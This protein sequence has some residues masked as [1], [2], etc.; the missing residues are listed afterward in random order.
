M[1]AHISVLY[2]MPTVSQQGRELL[3]RDFP[4]LLCH[5]HSLL[6]LY[7]PCT[8]VTQSVELTVPTSPL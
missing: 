6:Q 7:L 4:S 8:A 1:A 3:V 5:A 2:H